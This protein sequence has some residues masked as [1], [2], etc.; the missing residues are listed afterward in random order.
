M[1][2]MLLYE[3][4]A[5]LFSKILMICYCL[6]E[7]LN[8]IGITNI[9][10]IAITTLCSTVFMIELARYSVIM[11]LAERDTFFTNLNFIILVIAP[12]FGVVILVN[13]EPFVMEEMIT[14]GYKALNLLLL[15]GMFYFKKKWRKIVDYEKTIN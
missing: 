11:V 13:L 10:E 8:F 4:W 5:I 12:L 15:L 7:I 3:K 14:V 6:S 1:L 9:S 2:F